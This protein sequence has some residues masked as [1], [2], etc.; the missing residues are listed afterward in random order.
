MIIRGSEIQE[1]NH[2][3]GYEIAG[4]QDQI[5]HFAVRVTAPEN[6]F[7]PEKKH[8]DQRFWYILEG[9]N[10]TVR[11]TRHLPEPIVHS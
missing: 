10:S 11:C 5:G 1:V 7:E 6:L 8:G 2:R 9:I 4:V 3:K